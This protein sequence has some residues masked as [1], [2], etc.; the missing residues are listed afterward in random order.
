MKFKYYNMIKNIMIGSA[1]AT[2]Y[3]MSIFDNTPVVK[4]V[5]GTVAIF[6]MVVLLLR[7]ADNTFI[8]AKKEKREAKRAAETAEVSENEKSA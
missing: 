5:F 8:K 4:E 1:A 3:N 2:F 6:V 7:D